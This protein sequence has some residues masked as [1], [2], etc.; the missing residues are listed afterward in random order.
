MPAKSLSIWHLTLHNNPQYILSSSSFKD[1]EASRGLV[2]RL[3]A[4]WKSLMTGVW[5]S[6]STKKW[7][8]RKDFMKLSSD[9]HMYFSP[10]AHIKHTHNFT[11]IFFKKWTAY[12]YFIYIS[13]LPAYVCLCE[14]VEFL[15][16]GVTVVNCHVGARNCAASALNHRA[17]SPALHTRF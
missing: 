5:S 1:K 13:V 6:E 11:H 9:F 15:R 4:C 12:F 10:Y 8:E 3:S 2:R 16:T 17:N 7:K 14:C